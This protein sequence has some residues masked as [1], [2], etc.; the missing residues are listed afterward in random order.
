MRTFLKI[1]GR[2]ATLAMFGASI[3][4]AQS[5]SSA[6]AID[7]RWDAILTSQG[8]PIPF[9]LD[10]SG[11]GPTLKGTLY[12][13]VR[14]NDG[15]SSATFQNNELVL[16]LDQYQTTIKATL[17]D[18]KLTGSVIVT[19]RI[20]AAIAAASKAAEAEAGASD[21]TRLT[22][23]EFEGSS[24]AAS[25]F[26]AVRH[27]DAAA[28]EPKDVPQIGGSWIIPLS[29]PS[30]KGE[31]AF[32]FIV[33]QKGAYVEASIL[34][35]DGDTGAYSGTYKD[36][37]WVLSHYDGGRPGV[38][39]VSQASDGSLEI[40]QK[41]GLARRPVA[42]DGSTPA[43]NR[44]RQAAGDAPSA[45]GDA[46]ANGDR[47]S[48]NDAAQVQAA[49]GDIVGTQ[50][51]GR[52]SR[53]LIAYRPEVE[54]AK[55]LPDPDD[56]KTHTSVRD[57]NEVFKFNFPDDH[58]KLVS[59]EDPRFKGKVVIAMVTGTWCPN[60]HDEAQYLVQLYAK[61]HSKGLEIV[62]LDFEEP[63]Q[64]K[65]LS[66]EQAFVKHYGVKYTYLIAGDR[67]QVWEKI[68]YFTNLNSW[69]TIIFIGR[70]GKV[71]ATHTGF[72]SPAS[73]EFYRQLDEEFRSN[74]EKLLAEKAPQDVVVASAAPGKTGQ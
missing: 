52:Y 30:A 34:R 3:A 2:A 14:P 6:A 32:R 43:A 59:N 40:V 49:P 69:P 28:E 45:N 7:G 48:Q 60:C 72:A 58:G 26:E 64:Q 15:T 46:A 70:D 25:P 35:V 31:N 68:P 21:E 54:K 65:G 37:K 41:G 56:Y 33:E 44:R 4:M 20:P 57:P 13:G 63:D 22:K 23:V 24:F 38:I 50:D 73:G 61:Y 53:K 42:K 67:A 39:E 16:N 51:S 62:A 1:A 12:D 5:T 19:T 17:K 66:R 8:Q 18:G 9:R 71:K 11:S 47:A 27:V 29:S 55:G 10:I 74:V 36:G